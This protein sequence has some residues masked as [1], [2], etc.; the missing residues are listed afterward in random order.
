MA[1]LKSGLWPE[2]IPARIQGSMKTLITA[3]PW[4]SF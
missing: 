4:S 2:E 1:D 3:D